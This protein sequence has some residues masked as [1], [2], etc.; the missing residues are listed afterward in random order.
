MS[1]L[2]RLF[3]GG[4][5]PPSAFNAAL[6]P[7]APVFVIGDLH[8]CHR[9]MVALEAQM[10]ARDPAAMRVYVGDYV[11]RGEQ[12]ADVLRA[13]YAMRDDPQVICLI[14]NHEDMLFDFL[15]EPATKGAR[16]LRYG[17]LQTLASFGIGGVTAGTKGEA[18]IPVA[19]ALDEAMGPDLLHWLR[20]RP[21]IWQSGN[22]AVVHA[23]ADPATP[24]QAQ[25]ANTFKWGHPAFDTTPRGDGVWVVHGHTIV[26]RATASAGRIATDTG[27]YATGTLTAAYITPDDVT[28]L[29]T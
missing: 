27:A 18:L 20:R 28:F 16:W 14:G 10:Q 24:L 22:V 11:D 9:Q 4:S 23:G 21:T 6:A 17:G 12:S 3:G 15:D 8:G 29:Q 19:A 5:P 13:I 1:L 2:K 26:D 7:D 25:S